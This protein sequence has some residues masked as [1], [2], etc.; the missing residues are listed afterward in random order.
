MGR[1]PLLQREV[2]RQQLL[3]EQQPLSFQ[4]IQIQLLPQIHLRLQQQQVGEVELEV[5][6]VAEEEE[7]VAEGQVTSVSAITSRLHL[8]MKHFFS[9][10]SEILQLIPLILSL[11]LPLIQQSQ[12]PPP[13]SQ[14]VFIT[15]APALTAPPPV[16]QPPEPDHHYQHH[17]P[18]Y[19]ILD[20]FAFHPL[21]FYDYAL[22]GAPLLPFRTNDQ[23]LQRLKKPTKD[24]KTSRVMK[25]KK[26]VRSHNK[27]IRKQKKK[28][29]NQ[30]APRPLRAIK[31]RRKQRKRL[32]KM[33]TNPV[34]SS[35]R[36]NRKKIQFRRQFN[37]P[38]KSSPVLVYSSDLA[39]GVNFAFKGKSYKLTPRQMMK[40]LQRRNLL[41]KEN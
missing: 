13:P 30:V 2:G 21:A 1:P 12:T 3:M 22:F 31:K 7:Q 36:Q 27:L 19:P 39:R 33:R 16:T 26:K 38:G 11:I 32:I 37:L 14:I 18:P 24:R 23:I 25:G 20:P 35:Q 15:P 8:I 9:V 5:E 28:K 40:V 41:K 4:I 34:K 29:I 6:Q 17:H 10:P